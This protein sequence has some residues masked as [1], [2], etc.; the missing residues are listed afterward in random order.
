MP[1]DEIPTKRLKSVN[2]YRGGFLW[3][4]IKVYSDVK[5]EIVG[6]FMSEYSSTLKNI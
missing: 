3:I 5:W 6:I 4:M 1:S 2:G